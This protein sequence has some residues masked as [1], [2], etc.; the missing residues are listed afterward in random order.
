MTAE[1]RFAAEATS[2]GPYIPR[3]VV[4]VRG[5][6]ENRKGYDISYRPEGG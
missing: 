1:A 3:Q 4:V 2:A 5:N 6:G